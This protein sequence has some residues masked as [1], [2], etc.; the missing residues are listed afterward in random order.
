MVVM[1]FHSDLDLGSIAGLVD[2]NGV[3]G[4]ASDVF[5]KFGYDRIG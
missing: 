3:T 4:K 2:D 5:L 1:A